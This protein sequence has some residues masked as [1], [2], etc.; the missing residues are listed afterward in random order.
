MSTLQPIFAPQRIALLGA[1]RVASLLGPALLQAGHQVVS[2]W[3]RTAVS[4]QSL[5]AQLSGAVVSPSLDFRT[6]PP[7]DL[8][9]LSVPDAAV[10]E[11]LAGA[12]FPAGA[13][14]AHTAGALPLSLFEAYPKVRGGVFYPLQTF[15]PGRVIDWATVPLCIEAADETGQTVLMALGHSLSNLVQPVATLQRQRLHVAAVF[16]SNFTNH[17]LGISHALLSEANLPFELLAPL[18]RETVEKAI[19]A[20]PFSVQTGPAARRDVP[21]LVRHQAELTAHPA[22]LALYKSLSDSIQQQL[23]FVVPNNETEL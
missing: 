14:I 15:S 21:T 10:P 2:V 18:L 9:L 23:P 8:Y 20:P 5:A 16:A 22:W 13:L 3:S 7:A 12:N 11:V 6:Q 17:L 19:A 4:A 1:G